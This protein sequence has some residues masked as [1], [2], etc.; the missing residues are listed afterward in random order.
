[1]KCQKCHKEVERGSLYCPNCLTEIP[2]V[3]EYDSV[4]T[5]LEKKRQTM[6][7]EQETGKL[8]QLGERLRVNKKR[9]LFFTVLGAVFIGSF[10]YRQLHT[11]SALY[12]KAEKY[13]GR[14]AYDRAMRAV[15]EALEKE[16]G[17]LSANLLFAS[18][19]KQEGD[20]ESAIL[21]L[22]P[23]VKEYPDSVEAASMLVEYLAAEHRTGEIRIFLKNVTNPEILDACR[24][25]ICEK[26]SLSIESGI[27]TS[28]LRRWSCLQIM[29][30]FIIHWTAVCLT[31]TVPC[32]PDRLQLEK[33][34]QSLMHLES[35]KIIFPAIFFLLNM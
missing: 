34:L 14:G 18:L 12:T 8:T 5:Q 22:Q 11:F 19:L 29:I 27:Y 26:P 33:E 24:D 7:A 31:R 32:M 23:M 35:I 4:E 17:N 10:C 30:K 13:Y 3:K 9:I 20:A 21:V 2:W 6:E 1:M 25:Y 16:P 15:E 28:L